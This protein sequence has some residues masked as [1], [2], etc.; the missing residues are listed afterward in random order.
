MT[1]RTGS[2]GYA[3]LRVWLPFVVVSL[4]AACGGPFPQSTLIPKGDF[5]HMV[6]EVFKSTVYWAIVVFVLVE[7]ALVFAILKF[8]QRPHH[9][10]PEQIHGN[11]LIEVIWTVIPAAILTFIAVP[12]V[13]TIFRTAEHPQG[14]CASR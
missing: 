12:T 2:G 13:R 11:T 9:D 4:L 3:G 14:R 10:E 1:L 6:D 7:G 8:R 5:A